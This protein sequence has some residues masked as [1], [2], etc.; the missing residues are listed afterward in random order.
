MFTEALF[1]IAKTQ[2]QPKCPLTDERIKKMWCMYT[3]K[4]YS[5]IKKKKKWN[6]AIWM[7]QLDRPREYH[8]KLD[9]DKYHMT[10]LICGIKNMTQIKSYW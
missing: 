1:T 8:T 6:N 4:Y 3:V 10:S 9:N 5:V 2:E 7:D